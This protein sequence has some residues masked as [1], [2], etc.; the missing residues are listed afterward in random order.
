MKKAT[1]KCKFCDK[2]IPGETCQLAAYTT[3][4]DGKTTTF[5]C[6]ICAN[7]YKQEKTK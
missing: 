1:T 7:E 3:V 2:E 5:C 6:Q 4:I